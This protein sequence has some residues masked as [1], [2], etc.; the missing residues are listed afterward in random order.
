MFV[1]TRAGGAWLADDPE[2]YGSGPITVTGDVD[3]YQHLA[4]AVDEGATPYGDVAIEYPPGVL[5]FMWAPLAVADDDYRAAFIGLMLVLD[6][7]GLAGVVVMARRAGSWRGPWLWA[8]LVPALGPVVYCRLDMAPA[9]ATIWA[10]ERAQAKRWSGAGALLG[11]GAA[12]KLYPAVLLLVALADRWRS[13]LVAGAVVAVAVCLL[14]FA[15]VLGEMWDS[16]VGYHGDRGLQVES[17]GSAVL[18]AAGHLDRSVRVVL[19][20]GAF[21]TRAAG[22]GLLST[23]STLSAVAIVLAAAWLSRKR[24][25]QGAPADSVVVPFGTIALL[26][27]VT[28][29]FSPQYML[30]L[31]AL[32]A[33]AAGAAGPTLR[34]PLA[35]LALANVLTQSIFPFHYTGLLSNRAGPLAL[36]ALRNL[37]VAALGALVLLTV[38][39]RAPGRPAR[40]Q[41]AGE[42]ST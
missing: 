26:L 12:T 15:A 32:G 13:R 25:R 4:R 16:V 8:L 11:F 21:H 30:W 40:Q 35:L 39:G 7:A 10:F 28:P 31:T 29:V 3:R 18:L 1:V 23:A 34:G 17:T 24:A 14:P 22:A 19:D 6:A 5:P 42:P 41:P 37:S 20:H 33:V 27:A 36:L 2:R 9:V 38:A